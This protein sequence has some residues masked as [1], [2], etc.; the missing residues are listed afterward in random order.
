MDTR[1]NQT[2]V[3]THV[4]CRSSLASL[5][6]RETESETRSPSSSKARRTIREV[7]DGSSSIQAVRMM[8]VKENVQDPQ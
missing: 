6:Q 5:A 7:D 4:C 8:E 2:A 1:R 3:V